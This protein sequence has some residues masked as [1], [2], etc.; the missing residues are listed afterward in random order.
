MSADDAQLALV[1]P[2]TGGAGFL[3]S[4]VVEGL[5]ARGCA[6]LEDAFI[7]WLEEAN[8]AQ[9]SKDAVAPSAPGP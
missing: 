3:G 8:A 5:K 2:L 1:T 4:F 6:N 9:A 7:A